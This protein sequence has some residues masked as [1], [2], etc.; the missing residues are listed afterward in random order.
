MFRRTK[1]QSSLQP[2]REGAHASL[3]QI[4][5]AA[6][7]LL[8]V[9]ALLRIRKFAAVYDFV[10]QWPT[11]CRFALAREPREADLVQ[12]VHHASV[13]IPIRTLCLVYSAA[14]A[15]LLRSYGIR[16]DLVIGVTHRPFA[17]HTWV[18]VEGRIIG[19]SKY[20]DT[21]VVLDRF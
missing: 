18:E 15:V 14:L 6:L 19:E 7:L 17:G 5:M 11:R 3:M 4:L 9:I 8:F 20:T 1:R 10:K 2:E 16:A 21:C 12:A 13:L